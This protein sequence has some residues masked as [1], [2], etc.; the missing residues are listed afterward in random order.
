MGC[1]RK[2]KFWHSPND[3]HELY[4]ITSTMPFPGY[5]QQSHL[6]F[7]YSSQATNTGAA[8]SPYQPATMETIRAAANQP[9]PPPPSAEVERRRRISNPAYPFKSPDQIKAQKE[10][11][12]KSPPG[13]RPTSSYVLPSP[14][15]QHD[16]YLDPSSSESPIQPL[17]PQNPPQFINPNATQISPPG[18][19]AG[20]RSA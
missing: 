10:A 9:P 1:Q 12:K 17:D 15:L 2:N 8:N 18:S 6:H 3:G 4:A 19:S 11:E 7:P 14:R 13:S 16:H 20:H 5:V